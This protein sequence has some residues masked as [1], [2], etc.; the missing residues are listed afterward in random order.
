MLQRGNTYQSMDV[1]NIRD[2][3]K[4]FG[5]QP[6]NKLKFISAYEKYYSTRVAGMHLEKP[7]NYIDYNRERAFRELKEFCGFEYYGRKH[8]E[9]KF[10]AFLQLRWL[11]EKFGVD[12][13]LSHL[14]SMIVSGQMTREDALAEAARPIC[15]GVPMDE[16][17]AEIKA[18]MHLSDA[19]FEEIMRAPTHQHTEYKTD[20]LD[21]A[22]RSV[23]H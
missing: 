10:T 2:I 21:A 17:V 9:N 13:R 6:I 19:E 5:T 4:R 14:S 3:H 11:P 1:V 12:K 22:L 15:E 16:Y 20:R 7:L 18:N 23:L 8:L